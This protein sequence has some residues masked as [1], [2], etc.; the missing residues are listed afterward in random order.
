MTPY[1]IFKYIL[2]T[3]DFPELFYGGEAFTADQPQSFTCPFCGKMGFTESLLQE[4][5]TADHAE[6]S[7]EVVRDVYP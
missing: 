3:F 1:F 2:F 4:H 5:I 6:T 7:T